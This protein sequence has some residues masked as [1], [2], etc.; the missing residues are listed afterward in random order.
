MS[1]RIDPLI[2]QRLCLL[3]AA[4]YFSEGRLNMPCLP[5]SRTVLAKADPALGFV[6][7]ARLADFAPAANPNSPLM[8]MRPSFPS[9]TWNETPPPSAYGVLRGFKK[10]RQ[11]VS[12][13]L[14]AKPLEAAAFAS[15]RNVGKATLSDLSSLFSSSI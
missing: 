13:M 3:T 9:L 4:A 15:I 1:Y 7:L 2:M 14:K 8:L 5:D 11:S 10:M 6:G 12:V